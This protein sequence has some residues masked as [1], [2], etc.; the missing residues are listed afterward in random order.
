MF[1]SYDFNSGILTP[2]SMSLALGFPNIVFFFSLSLLL[3]F[4]SPLFWELGGKDVDM[5]KK[6][7]RSLTPNSSFHVLYSGKSVVFVGNDR[8]IYFSQNLLYMF[9]FFLSFS[10]LLTTIIV[11]QWHIVQ[12]IRIASS[13]WWLTMFKVLCRIWKWILIKYFQHCEAG[14]V[15]VLI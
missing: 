11:V 15:I 10:A 13:Y 9:L 5:K 1:W 7:F 12:T 6:Q 14:T 8:Q 2:Q 4:P 3:S